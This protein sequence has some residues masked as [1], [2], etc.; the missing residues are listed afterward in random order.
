[1]RFLQ[2]NDRCAAHAG[3]LGDVSERKVK[4][5]YNCVCDRCC[6]GGKK[7]LLQ[8]L[9]VCWNVVTLLGKWMRFAVINPLSPQRKQGN[10]GTLLTSLVERQLGGKIVTGSSLNALCLF[11]CCPPFEP[12]TLVVARS[13]KGMRGGIEKRKMKYGP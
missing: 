12:G 10:G 6:D 4:L 2:P 7:S 11:V 13:E 3:Q 5:G 8:N 1:V 9:K